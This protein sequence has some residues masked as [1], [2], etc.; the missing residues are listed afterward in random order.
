VTIEEELIALQEENR[1][2]REHLVQRDQR[3]QQ[4]EAVRNAL[5]AIES[6]KCRKAKQSSKYLSN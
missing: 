3:I 4:L 2:L 5:A 6:P 1:S